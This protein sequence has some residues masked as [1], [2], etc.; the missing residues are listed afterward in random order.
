MNIQSHHSYAGHTTTVTKKILEEVDIVAKIERTD[1]IPNE[2]SYLNELN[3]YPSM[4]V[5][6]F[7]SKTT[8]TI[9]L[10]SY[11]YSKPIIFYR[12]APIYQRSGYA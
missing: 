7:R 6:I 1:I 9:F 3:R 10:V 11:V 4:K 12:L 5:K 2:N 8:I